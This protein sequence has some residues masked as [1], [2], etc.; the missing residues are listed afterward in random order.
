MPSAAVCLDELRP[1]RRWAWSFRA[2]ALDDAA[3][4]TR[5]GAAGGIRSTPG[6]STRRLVA[7]AV[8]LLPIVDRTR[9]R[10]EF[11]VE[12]VDL[13]RKQQWGYALQALARAWE[14]RKALVEAVRTSDGEPARQTER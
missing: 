12:L 14:L 10:E 4:G 11:G 8:R 6:R 7:L 2:L 9:Y 13:P 1:R 5:A 3:L